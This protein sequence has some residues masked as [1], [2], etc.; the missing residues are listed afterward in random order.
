MAIRIAGSKLLYFPVPKVA[1]TSI[2]TFIY[3]IS[4][5]KKFEGGLVNGKWRHIHNWSSHYLSKNF[6]SDPG[7]DYSNFEKIVVVRD[8]IKRLLSA[9]SNRVLYHGELNSDRVDQKLMECLGINYRPKLNEFVLNL[10]KY[11]VCSPSISHHLQNASTF[12]GPGLDFFEH[13]YKVEDTADLADMINK[14]MGTSVELGRSQ[15]EGKKVHFSDLSR[16]AQVKLLEYCAGD[17]ALLRDYYSP[18]KLT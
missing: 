15:T 9:Y 18:P 7:V 11:C 13:V 8:P 16:K 10:E 4:F 12:V 2:K 17:Y 5:G 6:W 14:R 3:E 1:C